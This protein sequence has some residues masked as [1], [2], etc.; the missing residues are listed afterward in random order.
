MQKCSQAAQRAARWTPGGHIH[1]REGSSS[2]SN[3]RSLL[4][5]LSEKAL[6]KIEESAYRLLDEVGISFQHDAATEMLHGL[7]C[8]V[9]KER[10]FIP[11]DSVQR[12]LNNVTPQRTF[13]NRDGTEAFGLGDG[14][15]RFHSGGG[16]PFIFDLDTG[17][18][19]LSHLRDVAQATRL[20]DALAN[21]DVIIPLFGPQD[22]APELLTVTSTEVTLRNTHKPVWSD[23]MTSPGTYSMWSRWQP[24][25]VVG[26]RPFAGG[27]PCTSAFLR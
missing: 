8:R 15:I 6:D 23:P 11:H 17:E 16:L 27:R 22:V 14:Q 10:V 24:P 3:T 19:R 1:V 7:G 4:G 9:E 2:M 5:F 20:L 25:A 26:W 13:F 12:S 21:V 18:R